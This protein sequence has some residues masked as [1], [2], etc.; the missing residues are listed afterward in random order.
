MMSDR[1]SRPIGHD[2][3]M[4]LVRYY[5]A[6]AVFIAHFNTVYGVEIWFPTTSY[7]AVGGFF[8]LSGF[9]V[10][11]S[12]LNH[13]NLRY[14]LSRRARR[15]FPPYVFIVLLCA[16][17][18]VFVS[19]LPVREYFFNLQ[20]VKYIVCNLAFL[21]FL[22]PEL[23][24]VFQDLPVRAVDGSLW[25]MKIEV[26]LYLSVPVAASIIIWMRKR[27]RWFSPLVLCAI[28][29]VLSSAYRWFLIDLY[30]STHNEFY[31]IFS[32]QLFGQ[33]MFFYGGVGVYFMYDKF[34]RWRHLI[35]IACFAII[36]LS[37][38]LPW[39]F[40]TTCVLPMVAVCMVIYFSTFRFAGFLNRNNI[41]Y[42]VYLYHFPVILVI[43]T[44]IG[45]KEIPLWIV[46]SL[47][48]ACTIV[49][50][51]VSWFGIGK[52]FLSR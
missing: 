44:L 21:N 52:K 11:P 37:D 16:F 6:F 23:P 24:G 50:G 51:M 42:D 26:L 29:Y 18:L 43:M 28:V 39:M 25:T 12:Y 32:R 7:T 20:W 9:L 40:Y 36:L 5:L 10:Y 34:N 35:I 27:V 2:N 49:L 8:A 30:Y 17:S 1:P 41:S 19:T 22:C 46:F 48:V 4:G 14:Y 33:L 15:I 31:R 38:Y 45:G 13:R 47:T 3:S